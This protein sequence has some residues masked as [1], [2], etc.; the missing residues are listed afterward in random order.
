L[1][2]TVTAI[3]SSALAHF[4]EEP[5][6][7]GRGGSGTIFLS[8]C[9]CRLHF[10]SKLPDQPRTPRAAGFSPE[11]LAQEFLRLQSTGCENIKLGNADT[12]CTVFSGGS[13]AGG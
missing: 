12:T 13:G 4:G 3:L 1:K 8:S 10:L 7:T 5:P 11:Q 2:V 6:I 9:N